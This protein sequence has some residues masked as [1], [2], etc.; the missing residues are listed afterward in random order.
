MIQAGLENLY[1]SIPTLFGVEP[2]GC[3]VQS[4]SDLLATVDRPGPGQKR[5]ETNFSPFGEG[6]GDGADLQMNVHAT[7]R[8]FLFLSIQLIAYPLLSCPVDTKVELWCAG[9]TPGGLSRSTYG[10]ELKSN[11]VVLLAGH[12]AACG[13]HFLLT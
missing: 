6:M 5:G 3:Q 2:V 12:K 7:T 9:W 10:S 11:E 13:E 8:Q 4:N 1:L